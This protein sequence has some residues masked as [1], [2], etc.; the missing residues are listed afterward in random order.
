MS[1]SR[2][3]AGLAGRAVRA[4]PDAAAVAVLRS[5]RHRR[6]RRHPLPALHRR[7]P[8]ASVPSALSSK[9][10]TPPTSRSSAPVPAAMPPRSWP[11]ISACRSP[12]ST[13]RRTPA[14][15]ASTAAASRRRRCSTSP[16]SSTKRGTP[17]QFGVEFAPPQIDLDKLR[18]FKDGVVSKMTSGTGVLTRSRK[19]RYVQGRA[20]HRRSEDD[21]GGADRAAGTETITLRATASSRPARGRRRCRTCRSAP[22]ASST[23][24]ARST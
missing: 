3:R 21:L 7:P 5:P 20:T 17:S 2:D 12:S 6:R 19:I 4:A 15:S 8:R 18:A 10:P 13:R 9:W 11:P 22:I 23:R 1:R 14:A 16:S 24:P